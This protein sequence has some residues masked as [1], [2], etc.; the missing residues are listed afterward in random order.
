ML[1]IKALFSTSFIN[2]FIQLIPNILLKHHISVAINILSVL[3]PVQDSRPYGRV[4]HTYDFIN[5]FVWLIYFCVGKH[6]HF[7]HEGLLC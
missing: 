4:D 5:L 1:V 7:L 3:S 6:I 2:F